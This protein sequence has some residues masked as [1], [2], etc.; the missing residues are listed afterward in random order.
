MKKL[1][2]F[3]FGSDPDIFNFDGR[4]EHKLPKET[5]QS[6]E[7]RFR[8]SPEY[9]WRLHTGAFRGQPKCPATSQQLNKK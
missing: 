9:N 1:L 4:V 3:L 2:N 5:W 7:N 8:Q 6:W